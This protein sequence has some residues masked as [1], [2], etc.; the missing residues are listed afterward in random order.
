MATIFRSA[1]MPA[2][3]LNFRKNIPDSNAFCGIGKYDTGSE[4][5]TDIRPAVMY[6]AC[7]GHGKSVSFPLSYFGTTKYIETENRK[8]ET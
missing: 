2:I 8:P 1:E 5:E 4:D 6:R 3:K 7:A